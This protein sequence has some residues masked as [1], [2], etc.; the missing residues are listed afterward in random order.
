MACTLLASSH[1]EHF[2]EMPMMKTACLLTVLFLTR[3]AAADTS[4]Y[5]LNAT[6]QVIRDGNGACVR[7][8]TWT[9]EKAIPGCDGVTSALA[10]QIAVAPLDSD[11]DGVSDDS[12]KCPSTPSGALVDQ[13]GCPKRLE[14]SFI[15]YL[16]VKFAFGKHEIQGDARAEIR[17]VSTFMKQYPSVK[18]T[19]EGY[20]DD[21]G[22]ADFNQ[23]LSKQRADA[24]IGALVADGVSASRLTPAAYGETHPIA[25]NETAAGRRENRRVMAYA[26]AD[27]FVLQMKK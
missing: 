20:T 26:Q 24:V 5:W 10:A 3:A 8:N 17:R 14:R 11:Q 25:T 4:G 16:D 1:F 18:V 22:P 27:T 23:V 2:Q 19:V 13:A 21:T 6:G 12:D 7:N 9:P 15:A